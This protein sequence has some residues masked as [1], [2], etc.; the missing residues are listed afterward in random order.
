M[1][2]MIKPFPFDKNP[3]LYC[4]NKKT[5]KSPDTLC[6]VGLN[7]TY[8]PMCIIYAHT[9]AHTTNQI[10]LFKPNQI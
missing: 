6:I 10:P 9:T 3:L 7:K 2:R 5:P 1:H 4:A 8:T